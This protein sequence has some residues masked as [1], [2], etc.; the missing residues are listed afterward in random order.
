MSRG[1]RRAAVVSGIVAG[2]LVTAG[3]VGGFW[4]TGSGPGGNGHALAGTLPS[5]TTPNAS[6]VARDATVGWAQSIVAG[7]LLGQLPGG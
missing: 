5:G 6:L 4:S 1:H 3:I 2:T 7:S